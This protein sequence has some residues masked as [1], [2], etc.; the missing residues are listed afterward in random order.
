MPTR[1]LTGRTVII[2]GA[3]AG[4]GLACAHQFAAAGC[5][6]VMVARG[7]EELQRAA[8]VVGTKQN[9]FAVAA[10]VADPAGPLAILGRARARFG[11][12]D[13]LINNAGFHARGAFLDNS[14]ED[15][16]R[17]VDVSL[18]APITFSRMVLPHLQ[19]AGGFIVNVASLAGRV[20]VAQSAVYSATKFGLRGFSLALNDELAGTGVTVSCVSPGP[21]DTQFIM[22]DLDEV[23][24]ITM[25]QPVMT[26][27]AVAELV[28]A[29]AR[30]GKPERA[31][32]R[33]SSALTTLGYVL[34]S[35]R[36]AM[37]PVLEWQGRRRKAALRKQTKG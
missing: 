3:S 2:T 31:A 11:A 12:V 34:P 18:R 13:G 17:M 10:D 25:S 1:Q 24:D 35:F 5:N 33:L 23:A 29:C 30:D 26:A 22:A 36:R 37:R 16:G 6:V 28:V 4:I 19:A 20:P 21:V 27:D 14:A 15:L 32:P 8:A 9:V 7:E